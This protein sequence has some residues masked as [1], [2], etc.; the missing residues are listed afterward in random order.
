MR[1]TSKIERAMTKP[2]SRSK[3]GGTQVRTPDPA[4]D[5]LERFEFYRHACALMPAAEDPHPGVAIMVTA[6]TSATAHRTCSC[7]LTSRRTCVHLKQLAAL[8]RALSGGVPGTPWDRDFG[9][10]LWHRLAAFM[11][12][13][14][15]ETPASVRM[16]EASCDGTSMVRVTD[17]ASTDL[18]T[19]FP[20]GSDKARFVQRCGPPP[21]HGDLIY[22]GEVINRM[23]LLTL[24]DSE[25]LLIDQGFK[26]RGQVFRESFWY[27]VAYHGYREFGADGCAIFPCIDPSDGSFT[28]MVKNPKGA[29]RLRAPVARSRVERFVKL[30]GPSLRSEHG[31]ALNPIPVDL[32]FD[33][34]IN[35]QLDLELRP[36]VRVIQ[37]S[38]EFK[39][40]GRE[41][42]KPFAYGRLVY[43]PELGVLA[44]VNPPAGKLGR[45]DGDV[46]TAINTSRV[47]AF[48]DEYGDELKQGGHRVD[49]GLA[50]QRILRRLRRVEVVPE[51]VDREDLRLSVDCRFE[52]GKVPLASILRAKKRGRR[53]I[54]AAGGWVD[55]D[56]Q[57]LEGFDQLT[58]LDEERRFFPEASD[59]RMTR[60]ELLRMQAA[61]P[62][63]ISVTGDAGRIELI[64]KLFSMAAGGPMPEIGGARFNLRPYQDVGSRWLWSLYD[65]GFGGLLCDDM[66]LGKTHQA[67]ALMLALLKQGRTKAP[68]LV[69][70]PTTVLSHWERKVKA[71]AAGLDVAIYH[72]GERHLDQALAGGRLLVTSYG[73]L[74]RDWEQ[75]CEVAFALVVFDEIQFIK[76]ADTQ[77]YGA[78]KVLR[79]AVKIGLTGTPIEN[80]LEELKNI[81]DLVVPGYL[82][83]NRRFY[84][85]YQ[86]VEEN[87]V[88][89][90]RRQELSRIISPFVLRRMKATVLPELPEK[91]EDLR[92]C[93][94]SSDQAEL[95]RQ[96]LDARR[97]DLLRTLRNEHAAVPYIHIFALLTLLKKICDHPA[98]ARNDL[99]ARDRYDCGKWD[100]FLDLMAEALDGGQKVVVYSQFLGMV[101]MIADL[102]KQ[103]GVGFV[104]LTG[105]S[106]KRGDIIDRF[107][108]DPECRVFVGSLKAGGIG[109]DLVAASVVIHYDRWW[110]AAREDQATDRVHRIGQTRGVQVFK[111]VT[112]DTLEEKIAAIIE[113]KKNLMQSV[114]EEDDPALLKSFSREQLIELLALPGARPA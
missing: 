90:D 98:L 87:V 82:G 22:I 25:R 57:E 108:G 78:A 29:A 9:E 77:T 4:P 60:A 106:R 55:C 52:S 101:A 63:K 44:D 61:M 8:R 89:E 58:D 51:A 13:T 95:Y 3:R 39:F 81:M 14:C 104:K 103:R 71:H 35:D 85:R 65:N 16:Y 69:V 84:E 20:A 59:I 15:H 73:I 17:A 92:T 42:L 86:M 88:S 74:R 102:L 30:F 41:D 67:M 33:V 97:G 37:K 62:Q 93:S 21:E 27:R 38:G 99:Q 32:I 96:A 18:L 105:A 40:F 31:R 6:E 24:T 94:L 68:F 50:G 12:E 46:M 107:N 83:D 54:G 72:G 114:V 19:Y 91:I 56:S 36:Q 110:N 10:S 2:R 70:C 109:I 113:R 66:G 23:K 47:P 45:L 1:K 28:I 7:R 64:K 43:V 26:S 5:I 48:M 111:L 79:A 100:L 49:G 75:L 34:K 76:N 80:R 112:E 53:F 11:A